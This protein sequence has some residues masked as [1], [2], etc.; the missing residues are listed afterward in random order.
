MV[1]QL[2]NSR[3]KLIYF[4][5]IEI[6]NYIE[7]FNY[8]VFCLFFMCLFLLVNKKNAKQQHLKNNKINITTKKP[9]T[10]QTNK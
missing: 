3:E 2:N 8:F 10:K 1:G 5:I 4:N 7:L 9:K 6:L